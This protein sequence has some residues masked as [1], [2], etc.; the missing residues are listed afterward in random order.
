VLDVFYDEPIHREHWNLF[1]ALPVNSLAF[2]AVRQPAMGCKVYS[3]S[4]VDACRESRMVGAR[5][6]KNKLALFLESLVNLD[7][8]LGQ[9]SRRDHR[10]DIQQN[11]WVLLENQAKFLLNSAF[12]FLAIIVWDAVPHLGVA[13]MAVVD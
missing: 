10:H 7:S 5:Q 2:E 13:P 8:K 11:V 12:E 9:V 1:F 3:L 4:N 6:R